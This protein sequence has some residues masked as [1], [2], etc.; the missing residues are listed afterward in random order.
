MSAMST[1][2]DGWGREPPPSTHAGATRFD[3]VTWCDEL[4]AR[5]GEWREAPL[6]VPA[7]SLG[8]LRTAHTDIEFEARVDHYV[9]DKRR[10]PRYKLY[11]RCKP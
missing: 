6:L 11:A 7:G 5:P 9:D 3:W 2:D 4:R 8:R 10:I 1:T